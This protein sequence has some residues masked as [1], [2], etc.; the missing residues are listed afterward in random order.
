MI[1]RW[2]G[3]Q[4]SQKE[5]R[6]Q[7]SKLNIGTLFYFL[8][9]MNSMGKGQVWYTSCTWLALKSSF[10]FQNSERTAKETDRINDWESE[11]TIENPQT[12][13]EHNSKQSTIL[14]STTCCIAHIYREEISSAQKHSLILLSP[15]SINSLT[16]VELIK[17]EPLQL[18][19]LLEDNCSKRAFT[20]MT[21][22]SLPFCF[23]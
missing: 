7:T 20:Q 9:T 4:S 8:P 22:E 11:R 5:S 21:K 14:A 19:V 18:Q 23:Q 10:W 6:L 15:T 13:V 17:T 16:C 3:S 2:V 12:D 1:Q